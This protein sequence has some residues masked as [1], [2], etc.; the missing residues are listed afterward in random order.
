[1]PFFSICNIDGAKRI[2]VDRDTGQA[3]SQPEATENWAIDPRIP[4]EA[5]LSDAFYQRLR[6]A[7]RAADFFARG[8]MTRREDPNW[9]TAPSAEKANNDTFHHTNACPQVNTAFNASK[10]VWQGI[11]NFIL[12]SADDSNLKVTVITGPVFADDDP[13]FEDPEFGPVR[14]PRRFWKSSHA[15]KTARRKYSQSWRTRARS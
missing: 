6:S 10:K 15:W 2:L 7:F 13:A 12:N 3:V 5:Q 8:H 4:E 9:G 14:L 11:E 1:M